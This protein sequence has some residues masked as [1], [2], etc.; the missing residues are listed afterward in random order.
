MPPAKPN[1]RNDFTVAVIC[2]LPLEYDAVSYIYDEFW[3]EDGDQYGRADGDTNSYTTGRI[4]DHNVVLALLPRMGKA[5]AASAAASLRSSDSQIRLALLVGVCGGVPRH[6]NGEVFL[7]DVVISRTVVQYDLGRQ[8]PDKFVQK[9]TIEDSL[10]RSNKDI[11]NLVGTF[12]TDRGQYRLHD[13]SAQF[14]NQLQSR[15]ND[16]RRRGKYD[17]PGAL[18]DQLFEPEHRHRHYSSA[19]CICRDCSGPSDPVCDEA[20]S[21]P[22]ATLGCGAGEISNVTRRRAHA[23]FDHVN[24]LPQAQIHVGVVASGDLVLKSGIDRERIR[25]ETGAI[26][27]EMEGAGVWDEMPCIV[28]K[29]VSDYA[30]SHKHKA[31]QNYAAATAAAASKAVLE[32][33]ILTDKAGTERKVEGTTAARGSQRKSSPTGGAVFKAPI[34]GHNVIAGTTVTGGTLSFDFRS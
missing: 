16:T 9:D 21:S 2:A 24:Q 26:A 17:Y 7:G 34:S 28:L 3:D 8:Y 23:A 30:D 32:R 19:I 22:C 1:D 13:R 33:Y 11:R 27:F 5:N 15:V 31:W 12:Q 18:H 6:D 29:A 14:L 20:L 25:K 10:G 4:G